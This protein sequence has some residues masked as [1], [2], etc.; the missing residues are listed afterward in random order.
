M[1]DEGSLAHI[2]ALTSEIAHEIVQNC[3][4]F[5]W[6][7]SIPMWGVAFAAGGVSILQALVGQ[8][9]TGAV[10]FGSGMVTG[11]VSFGSGMAP[12]IT[13][14]FSAFKILQAVHEII[15]K[16]TTI[17][18][19]P[20]NATISEQ[21]K[22]EKAKEKFVVDTY[23][24]A[25]ALAWMISCK[26]EEIWPGTFYYSLPIINFILMMVVMYYSNY[27][28]YTRTREQGT[29]NIDPPTPAKNKPRT[30]PKN[31]NPSS[32][33]AK[34]PSKSQSQVQKRKTK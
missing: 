15:P 26:L 17:P 5:I 3:I 22:I 13:K 21:A 11:A 34:S 1:N 10:S 14:M 12:A 9:V 32:A 31:G 18:H 19:A 30:P 16:E 27:F 7:N 2:G 8:L 24:A 33:R 20:H 28:F 23:Q 6:Q 25:F 4:G 29:K